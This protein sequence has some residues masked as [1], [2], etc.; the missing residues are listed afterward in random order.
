MRDMDTYEHYCTR[1][2]DDVPAG[3]AALGYCT[4]LRCGEADARAVR[5]TTAPLNKSGYMLIT[6][7]ALLTQLNPKRTT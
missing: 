6:D 1:C 4:C 3:R 5:H 2:G 7:P